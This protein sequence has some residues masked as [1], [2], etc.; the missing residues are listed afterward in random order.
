MN[1]IDKWWVLLLIGFVAGVI[2][3]RLTTRYRLEMAD[4]LVKK[5]GILL[6]FTQKTKKEME[7]LYDKLESQGCF[8]REDDSPQD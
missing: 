5:A 2:S 7:E 6:D 3:G 1:I 8:V 4:D